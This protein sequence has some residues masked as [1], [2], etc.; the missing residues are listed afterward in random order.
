M[1][2][3]PAHAAR[4]NCSSA[5]E[6]WCACRGTV[7]SVSDD[8]K[9]AHLKRLDAA[10]PGHLELVEADLLKSSSFDKALEGVACVL[11]TA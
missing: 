4:S 10:L 5:A 8:A 2:D 6:V 9:V 11:H 7:R 3:Q 1:K